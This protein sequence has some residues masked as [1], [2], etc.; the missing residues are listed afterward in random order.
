MPLSAVFF[1]TPEFAV[2]SLSRL[3]EGVA[4]VRLVVTRPD[5]PVGRHSVPLPSALA[6]LATVRGISLEKPKALRGNSPIADRLRELAPDLGVVVAYGRIL[7]A[8]ILRI[9]RLG[10]VNVHASLLPKYRGASPIQAA[11]LAGD[12]QTGVVT[13]K[14]VEELD[15]GPIYL[16]REIEIADREDA[17]SL[18]QRIAAAGAQL[19]EETIAGLER[20]TLRARPQE[21]TPIIC[22]PIRREDGR[23]DWTHPAGEIERRRRAF[24]PWPGLYT[25]LQKGRIKIHGLEPGPPTHKA[26]GTLWLEGDLPLVAAGDATS[27]ILTRAQRAGRQ[28]VGGLDFARGIRSLPA[29]FS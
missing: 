2:P 22:R 9:P 19:L 7:P 25:F 27:L 29:R 18:S 13:M 16:E 11:L 5:R 4:E 3:L 12:R 28:I 26:P 10:F 1:G 23:I 6:R 24:T 21:G 20:G 15:A 14:V 8:E 17:G